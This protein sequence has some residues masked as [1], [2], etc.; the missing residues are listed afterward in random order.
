MIPRLSSG[1]AVSVEGAEAIPLPE[2]VPVLSGY[3]SGVLY[4]GF[5][6]I[7]GEHHFDSALRCFV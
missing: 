2:Y 7:F 1:K 6:L 3:V 4:C 5:P